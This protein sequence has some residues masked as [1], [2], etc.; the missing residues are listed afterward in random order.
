MPASLLGR[1]TGRPLKDILD[2]LRVGSFVFCEQHSQQLSREQH[3]GQDR[4]RAP[5]VEQNGE[6]ALDR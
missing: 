5:Y 3:N 6:N 4:T 2:F 1:E